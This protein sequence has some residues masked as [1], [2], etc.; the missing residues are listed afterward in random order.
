MQ[1]CQKRRVQ[2]SDLAR[3]DGFDLWHQKRCVDRKPPSFINNV[4]A[5]NQIRI[6]NGLTQTPVSILHTCLY[7]FSWE[8][9]LSK[10]SNLGI[11]SAWEPA[12]CIPAHIVDASPWHL[13][14][15][16]CGTSDIVC[17][18][19]TEGSRLLGA[20]P[21]L[22]KMVT[23]QHRFHDNKKNRAYAI[24]ALMQNRA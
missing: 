2:S 16:A 12:S 18:V 23:M 10:T 7:C 11:G 1:A 3:E 4:E 14:K 17:A 20:K 22:C 6:R 13:S 15:R 19:N 24:I 8:P 21:F 5:W 9:E